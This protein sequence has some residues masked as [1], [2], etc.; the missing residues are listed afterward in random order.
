MSQQNIYPIQ[1]LNDLHNHFP[2][3]LYNPG[4]FRTIQDLL[5]YIRQVADVNPWSRGLSM[6]NTRQSMRNGMGLRQNATNIPTYSSVASSPVTAPAPSIPVRNN[7][8]NATWMPTVVT[9]TFS[10]NVPT[11]SLFNSTTTGSATTVN[12]LLSN[13]ISEFMGSGAMMGSLGGEGLQNFLNQRVPIRATNEQIASATT[14]HRAVRQQ[15]DICAIC[16]D[17]IEENQEMRRINHC[18]HYFHLDCIDTWFQGNVLCP[19]CRHDIRES[20][21]HT[22]PPPVPNNHRRTNIRGDD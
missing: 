5:D 8:N 1:L 13:I 21:A 7:L 20:Q 10:D 16:Q 9:A 2:D 18:G 14:Q 4:R 15:E 17:E 12:S 3:V 6:Y 19:T 11:T 22:S